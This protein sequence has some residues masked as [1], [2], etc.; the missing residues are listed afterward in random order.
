MMLSPLIKANIAV[1][2]QGHQDFSDFGILNTLERRNR[3]TVLKPNA[4]QPRCI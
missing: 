4:Q 1:P 2:F 3:K